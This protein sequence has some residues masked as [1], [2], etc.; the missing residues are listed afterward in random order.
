MDIGRA[1]RTSRTASGLTQG[2]LA[3]LAG[4]SQATLSA[5]ERG[6][7][8]PSAAT[9]DRLLAATGARLTSVPGRRLRVPR[10]SDLEQRGRTL[11]A[12][13]DLA[14]RLPGRRAEELRFPPLRPA[15]S[16]SR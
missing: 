4:T 8:V 13:I 16:D 7:K 3:A 2:E 12:V 14:E 1:L 10:A 9:L 15:T 5:Y 11:A 6:T